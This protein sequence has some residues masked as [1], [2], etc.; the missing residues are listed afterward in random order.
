MTGHPVP[1]TLK[2]MLK[3]GEEGMEKLSLKER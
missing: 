3:D 2:E 1:D